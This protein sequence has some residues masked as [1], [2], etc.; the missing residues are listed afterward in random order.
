MADLTPKTIGELPEASAVGNS[1]LFA[2]SQG[3]ASK[4]S[5]WQTIKNA[6]ELAFVKKSG[7]TMGGT[8]ISEGGL[9]AKSSEL[10]TGVTPDTNTFG[11]SLF[12]LDK[13]GVVVS[14]ARPYAL[15]DGTQGLLLFSQIPVGGNNVLNSIRIGVD[16]AG[17]ASVAVS[18]ALAWRR[19]LDLNYKAGDSYAA[20]SS[21]P[22]SGIITVNA[23]AIYLDI[24]V[25]KSLDDISTVTVS[26]LN[27]SAMGVNGIVGGAST[28]S[29]DW[30]TQTGVTVAAA[31]IGSRH[32]RISITSTT[33][34]AN[35]TNAT[36]IAFFAT[37]TLSFS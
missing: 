23:T 28:S 29:F 14:G 3:G 18:S 22:L 35:A 36:P 11:K 24:V 5:T 25:D 16:N 21:V 6:I 2:I 30:L 20:A 26:Q 8:L 31:K 7:D 37:F 1:D 34:F 32:V 9:Y 19:A 33:A 12:L 15:T 13:D 4:R 17:A 27:A 10:E